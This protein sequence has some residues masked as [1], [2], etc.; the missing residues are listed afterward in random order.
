MPSISRQ[1]IVPHTPQEMF[2]LVNDVKAYPAFLPGCRS[3]AV[4]SA[5]EDEIKASIELAKGAV[6]KSFT[7][8]NRLQR[9]KMIEMRLVDGP[10]RHLEGFWRFDALSEGAT[11]VSLDLEFEFSNRIMSTVIGPVFHQVANSLVDSFVK[12]AREVYGAR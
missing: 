12:R 3:S 11:R 9:N 4:L 6:R 7:T 8:R 10:F 2:D 1:A 5:D